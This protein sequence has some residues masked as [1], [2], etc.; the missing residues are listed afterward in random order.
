MARTFLRY[1]RVQ[2]R[3]ELRQRT[4]LGIAEIN[5]A[6]AV[7]RWKKFDAMTKA[8]QNTIY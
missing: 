1:I 5:A 6:P 8:E 3:G 2:S 7:H 4:L